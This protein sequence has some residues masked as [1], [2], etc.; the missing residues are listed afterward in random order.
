M[1]VYQVGTE[2]RVIHS[3]QSREH[4]FIAQAQAFV[5]ALRGGCDAKLASGS[6]GVRALAIC[7]AARRSSDER[8]EVDVV[9]P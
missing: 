7:D 5:G 6:D 1:T 9:Y 8:R 2:A 4:L 3:S